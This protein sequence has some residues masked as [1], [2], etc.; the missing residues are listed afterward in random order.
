MTR[1]TGL[2]VHRVRVPLVGHFTTAVRSATEL[3][4]VLV[5]AV[6]SDGRSGWGEAP[7]SRVTRL[8]TEQAAASIQGPLTA[9]VL[10]RASG[11]A[12]RTTAGPS[13]GDLDGVLDRLERSGEPAAARMAVDCALH[14]LAAQQL[15]LTLSAYLGG[16]SAA[17]GPRPGPAMAFQEPLP[18][19]LSRRT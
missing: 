5:E 14:D 16:G 10:G 8:S 6:D 1:L 2:R 4:T 18:P 17:A 11:T 9:L 12:V 7:I 13:A 19:R 3:E 15:G